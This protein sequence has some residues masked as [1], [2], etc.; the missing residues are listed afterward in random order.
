[1]PQP[2]L[3]HPAE[4]AFDDI[5]GLVRFGHGH[6]SE[7]AFLLLRIEDAAAACAWL[8]SAP[9]TSAKDSHPLPDTALQIAFTSG[10]LCR[11]GLAQDVIAGFSDEF[12]SGMA[13]EDNRSRRLGDIGEN[14]PSLWAWGGPGYEPDLLVMLY[15]LPGGLAAWTE[16]VK[17]AMWSTAF[18]A[19]ATLSTNRLGDTGDGVSREPFGFVDGISQPELDWDGGRRTG[20]TEL[21]YGNGVSLGEF[22]LGYQ[23]EYGN[24]TDRPLLDPATDPKN[25]VPRAADDPG[26]C[27]FG[28]NGTYLVLRDLQQDVRSFWQ[29]LEHQANLTGTARQ[30]LAEAMVGRTMAGE[31]LVALADQD[32]AGIQPAD[33]LNRF[34][35]QADPYG[36][37]CPL[38]AHIRRANPR[39]A[40]LPDGATNPLSRLARIFGYGLRHARD[41][42]IASTRF[43]RLLRRGRAYGILVPDDEAQHPAP[44]GEEIGLR[45]VCLNANISRQFEFVQ[46]AWVAG[47]KFA[48]LTQESDPLLGNRQPVAGCPVTGNFSVPQRSGANLR[49]REVP[50][51][52]TVRGG[53]YFFLP[54]LSALRYLASLGG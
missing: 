10:G 18:S 24:F 50:Q 26:K 39:N 5:Q 43:H 34:T 25:L 13:G 4:V 19:V 36:T 8:A 35:F 48:G 53:A 41:D 46:T 40:D 22:V 30:R 2:D 37:G 23:N 11:L 38:G 49:L 16:T 52:V 32:I 14:S 27:D 31:P 47:T 29:Y 15:A 33:R 20:V 21:T 51:F 9:V 45:F 12:L 1:M 7:A 42:L 6:L 44:P 54:S 17:G 3:T 28:R